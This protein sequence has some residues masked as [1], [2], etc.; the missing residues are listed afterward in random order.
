M[1]ADL[2]EQKA[3]DPMSG[4]E[5]DDVAP[6]PVAVTDA[7]DVDAQQHHR[8]AWVRLE[9]GPELGAAEP[10]GR[11]PV[12]EP[13]CL[14]FG[15]AV[16]VERLEL[17]EQLTWAKNTKNALVPVRRRDADLDVPCEQDL[18]GVALVTLVD[19]RRPCGV[20]PGDAGDDQ[21]RTVVGRQPVEEAA[22]PQGRRSR[23]DRNRT[24]MAMSHVALF[25]C[26]T[27]CGSAGVV[28]VELTGG[29]TAHRRPTE[30]EPS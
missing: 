16:G 11:R 22:R 12:R 19:E 28:G 30:K 21:V 4:V 24:A 9:E 14:R 27:C 7:A 17:A 3:G 1:R 15:S 23:H 26:V 29:R 2:L 20:A 18:H 10:F 5:R 25:V 6:P 13:R 8:G